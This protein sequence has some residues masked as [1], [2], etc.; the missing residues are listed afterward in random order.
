MAVKFIALSQMVKFTIL[1][2]YMRNLENWISEVV[3]FYVHYIATRKMH[4]ST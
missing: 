1:D 2:P 4:C 3:F